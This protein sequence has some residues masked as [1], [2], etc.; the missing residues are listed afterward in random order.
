MSAEPNSKRKMGLVLCVSF[1]RHVFNSTFYYILQ[2]YWSTMDW[3]FKSGSFT[4][5]HLR[6]SDPD[7]S[8]RSTL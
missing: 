1:S 4:T 2:K 3:N 6:S 8:K 7:W 5:E